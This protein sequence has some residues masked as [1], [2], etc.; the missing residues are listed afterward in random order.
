M[1]S[2]YVMSGV[3]SLAVAAEPASSNLLLLLS[4]PA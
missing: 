2:L 1:S 4:P 3:I